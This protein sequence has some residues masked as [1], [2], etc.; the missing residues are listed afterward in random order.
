MRPGW[1]WK[2]IFSLHEVFK[3]VASPMQV[4]VN[5]FFIKKSQSMIVKLQ[6]VKQKEI[7]FKNKFVD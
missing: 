7:E 3:L 1:H 6:E 5:R 4:A 2:M